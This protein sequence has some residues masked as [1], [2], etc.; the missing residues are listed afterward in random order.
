MPFWLSFWIASSA[1]SFRSRASSARTSSARGHHVQDTDRSFARDG[2]YLSSAGRMGLI[3]G[4]GGT[5]GIVWLMR[6]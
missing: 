2:T 5:G 3:V 4:W 6:G 1:F